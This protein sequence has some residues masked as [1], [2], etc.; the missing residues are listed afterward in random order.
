MMMP[1]DP[2][3]NPTSYDRQDVD[4]FYK[5]LDQQW[6][7]SRALWKEVDSFYHQEYDVW[8]GVADAEKAVRPKYHSSR[9]TNAVD[10]AV[11]TQLAFEPTVHRPP[12]GEGSSHQ[13]DADSI[14]PA[15]TGIMNDSF[16][17]ETLH[18]PKSAGR[19][20]LLYGYTPAMGPI[21][22]ETKKPVRPKKHRG[23]TLEDFQS[24]EAQWDAEDRFYNPIS[25][26]VPLPSEI[27]M[28]YREQNPST[29]IH[30]KKLSYHELEALSKE[31]NAK[32]MSEAEWVMPPESDPY[33]EM[34]VLEIWTPSWRSMWTAE[35]GLLI[36][37][38]ANWMGYQPI[39]HVFAGFGQMPTD[40]QLKDPIY[41]SKGILGPIKESLRMRDQRI[42][43]EHM[44]A[45]KAAM[46]KQGTT[47][48]P[49][50]VAKQSEGDYYQGDPN[51]LWWE[52]P[53]EIPQWY[54]QHGSEVDD[55]I[56]QGS[57]T[58]TLGGFRQTGVSTVGQ[59]AILSGAA[60]KKFAGPIKQLENLYTTQAQNLLRLAV[61][62]KRVST[63]DAIIVGEHKLRAA[64]IH[65]N[66]RLRVSFQQIDPI[67]AL[68]E[69]DQA[70]S[71]YGQGL[72]HKEG[73]WS[74]AH[75]ENA[76]EIRRGIVEDRVHENPRVQT[77]AEAAVLKDF[78]FRKLAERMESE[79]LADEMSDRTVMGPNQA[80]LPSAQQFQQQG[81]RPTGSPLGPPGNIN[82]GL[83]GASLTPSQEGAAAL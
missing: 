4:S 6:E 16:S 51:M 72:L 22:N 31:M 7:R 79:A 48:D 40:P 75:K 49:A 76:T 60:N 44:L 14:E 64:A 69:R 35:H 68:Q 29:A 78:G 53:P 55:D 15:V 73:Y 82:N 71:E 25:F 5:H 21:W 39:Q 19:Q 80:P 62:L 13:S 11:D 74:V 45:M 3:A 54:F 81:G 37:S 28:D 63:K 47:G 26:H 10:H 67:A 8:P 33:E 30:L 56:E 70:M 1:I 27:L 34:D 77:L 18:A 12:A 23:E 66:F 46:V 38:Q 83:Q 52:R 58:L 32:K 9:A 59:Q 24:R 36:F 2:T 20:L 43:G 42:I 41:L 57:F 17:R 61:N 50:Q 65:H